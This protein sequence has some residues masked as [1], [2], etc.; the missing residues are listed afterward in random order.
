[1]KNT[2]RKEN[3]GSALVK[4][5]LFTGGFLAFV[6]LVTFNLLNLLGKRTDEGN[7]RTYLWRVD[8]RHYL[9][10]TMHLDPIYFMNAIP[11][12]VKIAHYNSDTVYTEVDMF[13]TEHYQK[14][15][16]CGQL[17]DNVTLSDVIPTSLYKRLEDYL[18]KI[19]PSLKGLNI[20]NWRTMRPSTINFQLSLMPF[21]VKKTY[22]EYCLGKLI[23]A[24]S[25]IGSYPSSWPNEE[26][27]YRDKD[28]VRFFEHKFHEGVTSLDAHLASAAEVLN[29]T[30]GGIETA[31]ERCDL[32]DNTPLQLS[33]FTMNET[34]N[35][36]EKIQNLTEYNTFAEHQI[37]KYR[38]VEDI[39]EFQKPI[40][41]LIQKY[42]NQSNGPDYLLWKEVEDH[43]EKEM[44]IRNK[45]MTE[46]V[47]KLI[48][49][50]SGSKLFFAFGMAH[51][52]GENSVVEYLR[53]RGHT[54][55]RVDAKEK[56]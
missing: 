12:N 29:K 35:I 52:F 34:L 15:F 46:R 38:S 8:S 49:T 5:V 22:C 6:A 47:S 56:V 53:K 19:Q 11:D 43:D 25:C 10:G 16:R 39:R 2:F 3:V 13:D 4:A 7:C 1:M 24:P 54:V 36:L 17:E 27:Y 21:Y 55:E 51:F 33:I 20:T 32:I 31:Q 30:V 45:I 41:Q 14:E 23:A 48:K 44:T 40:I 26:E 9:F 42:S 18:E 50:S 28:K 37:N